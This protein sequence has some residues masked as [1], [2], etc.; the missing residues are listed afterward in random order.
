MYKYRSKALNLWH[1]QK[2]IFIQQ[3]LSVQFPRFSVQRI[4]S[5]AYSF[6][7]PLKPL[8]ARNLISLRAQHKQTEQANKDRTGRHSGTKQ[9]RRRQAVYQSKSNRHLSKK[10]WWDFSF[11]FFL[12][13]CASR[14]LTKEHWALVLFLKKF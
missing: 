4:A 12:H 10:K 14:K 7:L 8:R 2:T 5:S 11:W 13:W 9:R 6:C 1:T 3:I